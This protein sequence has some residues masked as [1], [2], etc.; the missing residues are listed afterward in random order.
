MPVSRADRLVSVYEEQSAGW[1][2]ET[3]A[4]GQITYL[5]PQI[6]AI[7]VAHGLDPIGAKFIAIFHPDAS[8]QDVQRSLSYNLTTK[9][10]FT[11]FPIRIVSDTT[12]FLWAISGRPYFDAAGVYRGFMGSAADLMDKRNSQ[13]EIRRLAYSDG[14]TGLANRA[15]LNS[16]LEQS[17]L[18][19]SSGFN[20]TALM[21]MDLDKFKYVNDTLGH[22]TGDALLQQ[23]AGRLQ[24]L[25][26]DT[27]LLGRLGGDEFQIIVPQDSSRAEASG[28]ARSII[29]SLSQPYDIDGMAIQIGCSIGI[30]IAPEHG[31]TPDEL[32]RNADLALYAAKDAGRGVHR[33]FTDNLLIAAQSRRQMEDDLRDALAKGEMH[34]AYQPIVST[35]STKIVGYEALLRWK[36]SKFGLIGPDQ[37]IPVAEECGLI[38]ALGEWV[39]RTA[40]NDAAHWPDTVRVA[41][42]VSPIQF[43]NPQFPKIVASA[44]AT[45]RILPDRL[46][47]EI[48]EGVFLNTDAHSSQMFKALKNIGVRLALDDFGTGYSS[49]GY[50]QNAPFDKIKIDKSFVR[51][52]MSS[53]SK[54][55]L[56]IAAIV[57]LADA[58]GMETT[59][60]GVEAQD[61]ITLIRKLGCSHIQGFVYGRPMPLESVM[62]SMGDPSLVQPIGYSISRDP[63]VKVFRSAKLLLSARETEIQIRNIS[64]HGLMIG[65]ATLHPD[66]IGKEVF[67]ELLEGQR[68]SGNIRWAHKGKAG[69]YFEISLPN[70]FL[71]S[72][73]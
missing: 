28:L 61:E 68:W 52:A 39:L 66:D 14:L 26:S 33:V 27:A 23:V 65:G 42:N 50:L 1:F 55:A 40:A 57:S 38:E 48:T 67:V 58:L 45:S 13:T 35:Q 29:A 64:K 71:E 11:G 19:R 51:G 56:I 59:A 47:L 17:L 7:L 62:T 22:Q 6:C 69:V 16:W 30:A 46:E 5:S 37:F 31:G 10:A 63:R 4:A 34:L 72:T 44:L 3:D 43:S 60:E 53:D 73:R 21:L 70:V 32:V 2:W 20:P 24:R 41:V 54:N 18:S 9:T 15:M 25:T 36:H 49:L 8:A 12:N